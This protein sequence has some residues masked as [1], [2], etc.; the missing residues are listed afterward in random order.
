MQWFIALLL[1]AFFTAAI[2]IAVEQILLL[3]AAWYSYVKRSW[4]LL[5]CFLFGILGCKN[6]ILKLALL[7]VS[8]IGACL[9]ISLSLPWKT[10]YDI[11]YV[12]ILVGMASFMYMMGTKHDVG[13]PPMLTV[14]MVLIY[15]AELL[16]LKPEDPGALTVMNVCA[17]VSFFLG[18]INFN[19]LNLVNGVH[20]V[21]GGTSMPV[22]AGLRLKNSV[23]F[24]VFFIVAFLVGNFLPIGNY[25]ISFLRMIIR[26]IWGF[27]MLVGGISDVSEAEP[28]PTPQETASTDILQMDI[29]VNQYA[30]VFVIVFISIVIILFLIGLFYLLKNSGE[31]IKGLLKALKKRSGVGQLD[32][33][34]EENIERLFSLRDLLRNR[35]RNIGKYLRRF[36]ERHERFEEMPDNRMKVRFAYKAMLKKLGIPKSGTPS[37]PIELGN[38]LGSVN[39][40]KLAA[41]YSE[42]RYND[43]VPVSDAAAKSAKMALSDIN[44]IKGTAEYGDD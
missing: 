26:G 44:K 31:G 29:P 23:L 30:H 40:I 20:N 42:A 4:P 16:L 6:R 41:D 18:L 35:R 21:K 13:F 11:I 24:A 3:D 15:L 37:T 32:M 8:V 9:F 34:Y 27:L 5:I 43:L 19:S 17:I 12:L 2:L 39:L 14:A 28:E 7:P 33:D 25:I 1:S 22:P 36:F 10:S 38:T